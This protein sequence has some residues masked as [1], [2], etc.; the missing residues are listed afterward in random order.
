MCLIMCL[1]LYEHNS[2]AAFTAT[3]ANQ[4]FVQSVFMAAVMHKS[5]A[6][7]TATLANF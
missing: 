4:P 3:S 1:F 6:L 2:Y 7:F 5:M